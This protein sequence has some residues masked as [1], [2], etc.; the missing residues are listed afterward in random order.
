MY[1]HKALFQIAGTVFL[2]SVILVG[3]WSQE[4]LPSVPDVDSWEL[5]DVAFPSED[6][7]WAVGMVREQYNQN[8]EGLVLHYAE[9]EWS[10][11]ELSYNGSSKWELSSVNFVSENEGWAVGTN[12][13]A[14]GS[15]L[16]DCRGVIFHYL[17]GA[18]FPVEA[19][20]GV[21][22]ELHGVHFLDASTGWVV[23]YNDA[24]FEGAIYHYHNFGWARQ[25]SPIVSSHWFLFDVHFVTPENGWAVGY[26]W[27]GWCGVLL[28]F[29]NGYWS[30]VPLPELDYYDWDLSDVVFTDPEH[31][32]AVGG[33]KKEEEQIWEPVIFEY[34]NRSWNYVEPPVIFQKSGRLY[35]ASFSGPKEGWAVGTGGL[36]SVIL[37]YSDGKWRDASPSLRSKSMTLTGVA[38]PSHERAW[39]VGVE[40]NKVGVIYRYSN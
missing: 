7:G 30:E 29:K 22:L 19:L 15:E 3:C 26:D 11:V 39:A 21:A 27:I 40:E 38:A 14:G 10:R 1:R 25:S 36:S 32:W 4:K 20:S 28:T 34:R 31:G 5:R 24:D 37:K 8:W 18:W 2:A 9:E 33:G 12:F 6:E 16:M 23:G 13:A 35:G 17:N